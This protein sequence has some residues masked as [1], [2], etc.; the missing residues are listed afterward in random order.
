MLRYEFEEDKQAT[1]LDQVH[2]SISTLESHV[3]KRV[4]T[5][6]TKNSILRKE[7]SC[8][9]EMRLEHSSKR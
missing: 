8:L 6:Q 5:E 1:N 3:R 7:V 4:E 9:R 2:R